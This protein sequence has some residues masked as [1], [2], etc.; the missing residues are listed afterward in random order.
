LQVNGTPYGDK[1]WKDG[2]AVDGIFLNPAQTKAEAVSGTISGDTSVPSLTVYTGD[3]GIEV[4]VDVRAQYDRT[5]PVYGLSGCA[6]VVMRAMDATKFKNPNLSATLQGV[7]CR[8]F[9]DAGF[10][11]TTVTTESLT[12][13]DGAKVRFKLAF[14]DVIAVTSV[15]VNS[16][17]YTEMSATNQSGNVFHVN[18][19]K[20]YIE[21]LTAPAA[22]ATVEVDYTYHPRA[23]TN[24]PASLVVHLLTEKRRGMGFDESRINWTRAETARDYFDEEVFWDATLVKR[25]VANYVVDYR[26]P[27]QEHLEA[28]LAAAQSYLFVSEGRFVIKPRAYASAVK[29]FTTSE[30]LVDSD[31]EAGEA[32][33]SF[34]A[35]YADRIERGNR[36]KVLFQNENAFNAEDEA[37]ADDERDQEQRADRLG[38]DGVVEVNIT[39]PAVTTYS[40]ASRAA[41]AIL[42]IQKGSDESVR[43]KT[44]LKGLVLEPGDVISI[45]HPAM[46][47]WSAREFWVD[48]LELDRDDRLQL[49]CSAVARQGEIS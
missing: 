49:T 1:Y 3:P 27:A 31:N 26:K 23:W 28:L 14:E 33:S 25:Y 35:T 47:S 43:F 6:Y 13:A 17:A 39:L 30:L 38:N 48:A 11:V 18:A 2:T 32:R 12:G 46:P 24:N 41:E 16:V 34:Q 19:K 45:T 40:Q 7:L 36:V 20:G 21:F 8:T 9:T 37:V 44:N 29:A 42:A 4:P 15:E 10:N 22:A 5:F